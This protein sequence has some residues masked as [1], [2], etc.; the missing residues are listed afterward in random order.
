MAA[1]LPLFCCLV[2][3]FS[4]AYVTAVPHFKVRRNAAAHKALRENYLPTQEVSSRFAKEFLSQYKVPMDKSPALME[5]QETFTRRLQAAASSQEN[6]QIIAALNDLD[7]ESVCGGDPLCGL[8]PDAFKNNTELIEAE[9]YPSEEHT[10]QT[11]DGFLLRA[12]R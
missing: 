9:G 8:D 7:F 12:Y 11:A 10:V 4:T 6:R 2:F 3:V 1:P 5:L